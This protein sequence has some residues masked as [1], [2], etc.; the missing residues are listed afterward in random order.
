MPPVVSAVIPSYNYGRFLGRAIESVLR[1]SYGPIECLVVDDGSTDDTPRV[2]SRYRGRVRV[3]T[4]PHQNA[5]VARN[6]GIAAS[7]GR[8]VGFL[9]ADDWWYPEK[10]A[11]QVALLERRAEIAAVGCSIRIVTA[12]GRTMRVSRARPPR[13]AMLDNVRAIALARLQIGGSMS[14]GLVRR[15]AL[16][17]IAGF[18]GTLSRSEDRDLW[19]RMA[20]RFPVANLWEILACVCRHRDTVVSGHPGLHEVSMWRVYRKAIR[21]WPDVLDERVRRQW[22]ARILAEAAAGYAVSGDLHRAAERQRQSLQQWPWRAGRWCRLA[23]L[24]L[25]TQRTGPDC[26]LRIGDLRIG[27]G[28]G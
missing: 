20:A 17:S 18:D 25:R 28:P 14:G 24:A 9:D 21:A 5:A 15:E 1:Q 13:R 26:G 3:L 10:I 8:Y 16:D 27:E 6:A 2:L 12:A 23:S 4:Q 19:L 22:R 7:S 11:R